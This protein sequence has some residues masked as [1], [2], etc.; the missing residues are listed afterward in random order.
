[1][2]SKRSLIVVIALLVFWTGYS[3]A[4]TVRPTGNKEAIKVTVLFFNDIH[5]HLMPFKVK[6]EDGEREV[7]GIARMATLIKKIRTENDKGG[8]KTFLLVAGDILQGTPM[9]TVFHGEPDIKSM[10]AMNVDAMT[11]GNHEFDFGLQNFWY[12]AC[13]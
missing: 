5:G 4:N 3:F 10:N 1:M 13:L 11:V 9:S 8:G 2:T 7:G 6:A 12:N